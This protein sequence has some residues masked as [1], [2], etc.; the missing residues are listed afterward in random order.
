MSSPEMGRADR[1]TLAARFVAGPKLFASQDAE[2]RLADW[3]GDVP[4]DVAT[5]LR[6]VPG[7]FPHAKAILEG[8]AEATPYLFDLMRADAG[9]VVRLLQADPDSHLAALIDKA[10]VDVAAAASEA[11]V[12]TVLRRMKSEA[13]LMIALCDIGGVDRKSVV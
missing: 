12:M 9:R 11:D 8:I 3:L 2:R 10:V 6:K 1:S 5:A 7:S 4:P 13:A